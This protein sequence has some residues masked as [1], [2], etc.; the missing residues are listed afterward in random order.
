MNWPLR[1]SIAH[2]WWLLGDRKGKIDCRQRW[3]IDGVIFGG[4]KENFGEGWL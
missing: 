1:S 4:R 2:L 3:T